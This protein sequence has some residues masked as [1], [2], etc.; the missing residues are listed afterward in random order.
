LYN[1]Y[2][3]VDDMVNVATGGEV[4]K[5]MD[6]YVSTVGRYSAGVNTMCTCVWEL[7]GW[8]GLWDLTGPVP[9]S[10]SLEGMAHYY[11]YIYIY[12]YI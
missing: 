10:E 9:G 1:G 3:S 12:I 2:N 11:V 6:T 4:S 7:E 5:V 8:G